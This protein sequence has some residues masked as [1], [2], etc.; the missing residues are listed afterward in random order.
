MKRVMAALVALVAMTGC[1]LPEMTSWGWWK[2]RDGGAAGR[3]SITVDTRDNFGFDWL[4]MM[5]PINRAAGWDLVVPASWKGVPDHLADI[6][7]HQFASDTHSM[8]APTYPCDVHQTCGQ[9]TELHTEKF[10]GKC[11]IYWSPAWWLANPTW[12]INQWTVGHEVAHCLGYPDVAQN[13]PPPGYLGVL[14]YYEF[15]N[16]AF[17]D[18]Y[19]WRDTGGDVQILARD[20]YRP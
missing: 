1:T 20:G 3:Q 18:A 6:T 19:W 2:A 14:N 5:A 13:P 11:R 7:F 9:F 15:Y 8:W 16:Q 10:I 4:A 12:W 17:R